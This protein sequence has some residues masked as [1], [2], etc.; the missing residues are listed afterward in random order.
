MPIYN[1]EGNH[2]K[3]TNTDRHWCPLSERYTGADSLL[4][5]QRNGWRVLQIVYEETI[6]L[7]G[8]RSTSIYYF[9]LIQNSQ[10]I[11]MPVLN[12][13]FVQ[14]ML[15]QRKMLICSRKGSIIEKQAAPLAPAIARV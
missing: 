3:Y 14:R 8:G 12:N 5:A 4:A 6:I 9:M 7:R 1:P 2:E 10:R 15:A 11:V 13:P